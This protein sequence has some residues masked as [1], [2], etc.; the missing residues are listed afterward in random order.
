MEVVV[1]APSPDRSPDECRGGTACGVGQAN[2][3]TSG[4]DRL[5]SAELPPA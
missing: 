3:P 4:Q 1:A 5:E 2:G